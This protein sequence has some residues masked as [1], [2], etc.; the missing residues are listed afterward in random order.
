M[1][2]TIFH[3]FI[4]VFLVIIFNVSIINLKNVFKRKKFNLSDHHEKIGFILFFVSLICSIIHVIVIVLLGQP[5]KL[6]LIDYIL[7]F[8][9]F[10]IGS[11]VYITSSKNIIGI[12]I[13]VVG[14]IIKLLMLVTIY[15]L[16]SKN[17]QKPEKEPEREDKSEDEDKSENEDKSE[18][19]KME[20]DAVSPDDLQ[21]VLDLADKSTNELTDEQLTMIKSD[22]IFTDLNKVSPVDDNIMI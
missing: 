1:K 17:K 15:L 9:V 22:D 6:Y 14:V 20:D 21:Y 5:F 10:G 12:F 18:V 3:I 4:S 8:I 2:E 7:G 11:G 19:K 16:S 13:I